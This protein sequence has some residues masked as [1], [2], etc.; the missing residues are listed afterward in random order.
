MPLGNRYSTS[1]KSTPSASV[2]ENTTWDLVRDIDTL[3][4]Y[5]RI[6][7][8]WV[9]F[10]GSWVRTGRCAPSVLVCA[11]TEC[12]MPRSGFDASTFVCPG[13]NAKLVPSL[14]ISDSLDAILKTYPDDVKGNAL[15]LCPNACSDALL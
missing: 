13:N 1:G 2:D 6:T 8:K 9:V 14:H 5:L 10:G 7:E 12:G 4:K 11:F 3:K 15:F